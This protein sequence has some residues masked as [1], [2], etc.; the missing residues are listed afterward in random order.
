MMPMAARS[1][2]AMEMYRRVAS[3]PVQDHLDTVDAQPVRGGRF[4]AMAHSERQYFCY[5]IVDRC[6]I[7]PE[8]EQLLTDF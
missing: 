5:V 1:A 4:S 8:T 2:C 7:L 3:G 6:I